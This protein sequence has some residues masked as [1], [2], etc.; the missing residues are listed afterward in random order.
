MD[1]IVALTFLIAALLVLTPPIAVWRGFSRHAAAMTWPRTVLSL[2]APFMAG[3]GFVLLLWLPSYHGQCGGWL[4]ET[5]PCSGFGQYARETSFWAAMVMA[6]PGLAGIALGV[7]I[8]IFCLIR[9][10]KAGAA[11]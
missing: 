9:R 5:S 4:G 11:S 10:R 2:L 7:A 1:F 6:V 3:Y 8:L